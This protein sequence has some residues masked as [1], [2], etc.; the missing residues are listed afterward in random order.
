M[1]ATGVTT[2]CD[3]CGKPIYDTKAG[4]ISQY[5]AIARLPYD[6]ASANK[7]ESAVL[8]FDCI[9]RHSR[10]R[11]AHYEELAERIRAVFRVDDTPQTHFVLSHVIGELIH[12]FETDN[13]S[14]NARKF[15]DACEPHELEMCEHCHTILTLNDDYS[16]VDDYALCEPCIIQLK[17][18]GDDH[19]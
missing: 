3:D 16:I 1:V 7:G 12:L 9:R 11:R 5:R 18:G 2:Y 8:C 4:T 17:V 13:P 10:F 15:L 19:A 6:V 14:F